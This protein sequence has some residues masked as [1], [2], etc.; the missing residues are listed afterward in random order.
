MRYG[1]ILTLAAAI[2]AIDQY[3]KH[4]VVAALRFNDV[5]PVNSFLNL[6]HVRNKGAAFG[7]LNNPDTH[8]QVWFFL[9]TTLIA[10]VVIFF[11][12]KKASAKD[13]LLFIALGCICGGALGNGIDRVT[14]HSVIDFL[15][16]Y[17]KNWHWPAFNIA[18]VAICLG[19]I[20]MLTLVFRKEEM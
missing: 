2:T 20:I 5:I 18:D 17:Y 13:Y 6:V 1:L 15:D 14:Q 8:W 16:A 11:L 19:A 12:A 4:L 10:L 7:F 9:G 3:V